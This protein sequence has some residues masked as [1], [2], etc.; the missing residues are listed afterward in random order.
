MIIQ[1]TNSIRNDYYY[2]FSQVNDLENSISEVQNELDLLKINVQEN[3]IS[4]R[5]D[6]N[7]LESN[8]A[9]Q[10][11]TDNVNANNAT[12]DFAKV[13]GLKV[14][15]LS[16]NNATLENV[17]FNRTVNN[18]IQ[19]NSRFINGSIENSTIKNVVINNVTLSSARMSSI[20]TESIEANNS[21]LNVLN[22]RQELNS[23]NVN[24]VNV[25]AAFVGAE[26]LN[27]I[28]TNSQNIITN[29]LFVQN[30]AYANY[31]YVRNLAARGGTS[32]SLNIEDS[33]IRNALL[34]NSNFNVLRGNVLV[35]REASINQIN[36]YFI[37]T[38]SF[39]AN[40][41]ESNYAKINSLNVNILKADDFKIDVNVTP[42]ESSYGVG[43]DEN[44]KLIPIEVKASFGLPNGDYV[45]VRRGEP[46]GMISE[47]EV[48]QS[49]NLIQAGAVLNSITN[50]GS[51]IQNQF[52]ELNE[53]L[54]NQFINI[55]TQFNN[56]F[57]SIGNINVSNQLDDVYN[58]FNDVSNQFSD[59]N[60][61]FNDVNDVIANISGGGG[62]IDL[63][64]DCDYVSVEK[65][66]FVPHNAATEVEDSTN[67]IQAGAV[68]RAIS[69]FGNIVNSLYGTMNDI[70]N[71]LDG[72]NA[73]LRNVYYPESNALAYP[74]ATS[75]E[76]FELV[77][78]NLS[79]SASTPFTGEISNNT[80]YIISGFNDG[81]VV[82]GTI[83]GVLDYV[84]TQ[85]VNGKNVL[86][87]RANSS[88]ESKYPYFGNNTSYL[89]QSFNKLNSYVN[90]PFEGAPSLFI[91]CPNLNV[92]PNLAR[93]ENAYGCFKQ[94][95]NF[96]Q[97]INLQYAK[98][99]G[100][101]LYNAKSFSST[102]NIPL[103]EDI[104]YAFFNINN[105]N[106]YNLNMPRVTNANFAFANSNIDNAIG[107]KIPKLKTA[108]G[109]FSNSNTFIDSNNIT[110]DNVVTADFM[111]DSFSGRIGDIPEFPN[112]MRANKMFNNCKGAA[113]SGFNYTFNAKECDNLF[114]GSVFVVNDYHNSLTSFPNAVNCNY[115]FNNVAFVLN[116]GHWNKNNAGRGIYLPNVVNGEYMFANTI[117]TQD[118]RKTSNSPVMINR[119]LMPNTGICN[120]MFYNVNA[121]GIDLA[122][123][124]FK[125]NSNSFYNIGKYCFY[126]IKNL[127]TN[128]QEFK[129]YGGNITSAFYNVENFPNKMNIYVSNSGTK[130][131]FSKCYLTPH[132]DSFCNNDWYVN[133]LPLNGSQFTYSLI[134]ANKDKGISIP[135]QWKTQ[136][137]FSY[138]FESTIFMTN[139][140]GYT[141]LNINLEDLNDSKIVKNM[142]RHAMTD[143]PSS[144]YNN[145][146]AF[147][148][149]KYSKWDNYHSN[150]SV[151]L[152]RTNISY[153]FADTNMGISSINCKQNIKDYS[154]AFA[155]ANS[156]LKLSYNNYMNGWYL[157]IPEE[158]SNMAGAFLNSHIHVPY[159]AN[160]GYNLYE[161]F[162]N[163]N[164]AAFEYSDITGNEE[165]G[166][167][168]NGINLAY[169]VDARN[170]FY[171]TPFSK[172]LTTE[173]VAIPL[174]DNYM[175]I[176]NMLYN[177]GFG[178]NILINSQIP[179]DTTNDIYN[180]LINGYTG[181]SFTPEKIQ[182]IS[183]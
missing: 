173:Y 76:P 11:N 155:N 100:Y 178:G 137:N 82:T 164:F 26:Q 23:F 8:I 118:P 169:A 107:L 46:K 113:Y 75:D 13:N 30:N 19:E 166:Y 153:L 128:N 132:W 114:S 125:Q 108:Y 27:T 104:S 69:G 85:D 62:S 160:K 14:D 116:N 68:L 154:Y 97:P 158:N 33:I 44:G 120:Y 140:D 134:Q 29:D 117:W 121:T 144:F 103:A 17:V 159:Y 18:L 21:K 106:A 35:S 111:F 126:G 149:N 141:V 40:I 87:L 20:Y 151:L 165:R 172:R 9:N 179:M 22:V 176:K 99:C 67:L 127:W 41:F 93:I 167:E 25:K 148:Y 32:F 80:D 112:V 4:I 139:E 156:Y 55:N 90:L 71:S 181:I 61:Q 63:P 48:V 130:S 143:I 3:D 142:F 57:N 60:N 101:L 79:F 59:I 170:C 157:P 50:L 162:K 177:T 52:T 64:N 53:N 171:N 37:N 36:S 81:D 98:D 73:G 150:V 174:I 124:Q 12:I 146:I 145:N 16:S 49:K 1:N 66:G 43:Y 47:N 24:A 147:G 78:G 38:N 131:L 94:C 138:M 86:K 110:F 91:S 42:V 58:R 5:Q 88:V 51:N 54:E 89:F 74:T 129:A 2:N 31:F 10:I 105:F 136:K 83:N 84:Y 135:N 123:C 175:N 95:K 92:M 45:S 102:I 28:N 168:N 39:G 115:M 119:I 180:C 133:K 182:Y 65:K 7:N 6:L 109:M 152:N 15:N 77:L 56:V 72:I 70:S 96:N 122:N 163:D 161:A 183:N 34:V